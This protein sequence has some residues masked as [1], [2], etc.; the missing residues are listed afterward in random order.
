MRRRPVHL[1]DGRVEGGYTDVFEFIC[2]GCGDNP[3]V[4]YSEVPSWLQCL[5]GPFTLEAALMCMTNTSGRFPARM[6]TA[7]E[8]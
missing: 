2:P 1:V 7:P 3:H 8:A 6:T 5:R 4:D